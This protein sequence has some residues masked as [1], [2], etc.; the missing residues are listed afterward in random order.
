MAYMVQIDEAEAERNIAYIQDV[1]RNNGLTQGAWLTLELS[2][3][4]IGVS[5]TELSDFLSMRVTTPKAWR[6]IVEAEK[7]C[8]RYERSFLSKQQSGN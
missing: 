7:I 6:V 3:K 1:I 5:K 2:K 8:K 4:G